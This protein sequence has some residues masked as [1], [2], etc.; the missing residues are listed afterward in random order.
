M[1]WSGASNACAPTVVGGGIAV[2][3]QPAVVA[4]VLA[5][6]GL[7]A[8]FLVS[9]HMCLWDD[10]LDTQN[11]LTCDRQRGGEARVA[12]YVGVRTEMLRVLGGQRA[13]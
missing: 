10:R 5:D 3:V 13:E 11:S 4:Q 1:A 8:D 2:G 12:Q 6:F 7:E 9:A